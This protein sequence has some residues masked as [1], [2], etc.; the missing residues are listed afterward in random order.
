M[1]LHLGLTAP[2]KR[3]SKACGY[4]IMRERG[5]SVFLTYIFHG[6]TPVFYLEL[7]SGHPLSYPRAFSSP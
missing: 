4:I 1:G 6:E 5:G 3:F 2:P 7:A